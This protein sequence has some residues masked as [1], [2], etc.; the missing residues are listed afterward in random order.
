MKRAPTA[1]RISINSTP[2]NIA[3]TAGAHALQA[4]MNRLPKK[5]MVLQPA[6]AKRT[7]KRNEGIPKFQEEAAEEERSEAP[8]DSK[9]SP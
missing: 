4:A 8:D 2:A 3:G 1:A 6:L 5:T 9:A 7:I